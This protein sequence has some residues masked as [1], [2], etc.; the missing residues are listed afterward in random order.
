MISEVAE[1]TGKR[2]RE[3]EYKNSGLS[4]GLKLLT[5]TQ[6]CLHLKEVHVGTRFE[7]PG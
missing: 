2:K 4:V 1:R 6:D 7:M 5:P 3:N